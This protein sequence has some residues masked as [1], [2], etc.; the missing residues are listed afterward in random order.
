ML[1]IYK[2]Y[3]F[4]L[5]KLQPA[6][7]RISFSSYP[8]ELFSDDDFYIMDSGLVVLQVCLWVEGVKSGLEVFERKKE[9]WHENSFHPVLTCFR[10]M[11]VD[12]QQDIQ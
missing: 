6:A 5:R 7:S 8:G 12:D 1:R 4:D 9:T 2:H 10:H 11:H 3:S